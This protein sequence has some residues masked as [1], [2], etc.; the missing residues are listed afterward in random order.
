MCRNHRCDEKGLSLKKQT[1]T[2]NTYFVDFLED[3]FGITVGMLYRSKDF[4]KCMGALTRGN[5]LTDALCCGYH[6]NNGCGSA[7]TYSH[8]FGRDGFIAYTTSYWQCSNPS[9]SKQNQPIKIS[10]CAGCNKI[11]DSRID[12]QKCPGNYE[13]PIY[14]CKSCGYC[15]KAHIVSGI[16]PD[17]GTSPTWTPDKYSSRYTCSNCSHTIKIPVIHKEQAQA[18]LNP[19]IG[20]FKKGQVY[21]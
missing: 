12:N 4:M 21:I 9:C 3:S 11:I 19:S 10:H 7:L 18:Q 5:E 13:N 14:I 15:C 6:D 8:H 1:T 20:A 2:Y 16:C 17:C